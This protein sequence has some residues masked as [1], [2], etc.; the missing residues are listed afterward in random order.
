KE[1]ETEAAKKFRAIFIVGIGA[2]LTDGKPHDG[3]APDYD[4]WISPNR[5]GYQ[6]LN[7]DIL[8]WNSVLGIPFELS[9]MGIRVNPESLARQLATR[10]CESR[11]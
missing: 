11:S 10:A 1:R 8:L 9:S 2:E 4:D 7:G 5:D 3:R 6:G